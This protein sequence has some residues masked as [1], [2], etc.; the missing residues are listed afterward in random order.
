MRFLSVVA[1]CLGALSPA[2]AATLSSFS[3]FS[4]SDPTLPRLTGYASTNGATRDLPR[5]TYANAAAAAGQGRTLASGSRGDLITG[6][7][8]MSGSAVVDGDTYAPTSSFFR[9]D[10][11][12]TTDRLARLT[13]AIGYSGAW[14]RVERKTGLTGVGAF[15]DR[16]V[17][18]HVVRPGV[19]YD[20]Q[21]L[22]DATMNG[23]IGYRSGAFAVDALV[24]LGATNG[25]RITFD[26]PRLFSE[27]PAPAPVPLPASGALLV[28][29]A[30]ALGGVRRLRQRDGRA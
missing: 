28:A 11:T 20:F 15:D 19:T 16:L 2:E 4:T 12:F 9:L 13:Y 18:S 25:A 3:S 24:G 29:A 14:D 5:G 7:I 17:L 26:D 21:L 22:I 30:A 6:A 1:I 23:G 8:S 27:A 10:A